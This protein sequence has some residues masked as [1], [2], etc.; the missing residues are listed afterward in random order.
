MNVKRGRRMLALALVGALLLACCGCFGG[1]VSSEVSSFTPSPTASP[2]PRP[3]TPIPS[4][5]PEPM[6]TYLSEAAPRDYIKFS[7]MV[8]RR[9]TIEEMQTLT[10][11]FLADFASATDARAQIERFLGYSRSMADMSDMYFYSFICFNQDVNDETQAEFDACEEVY[12]ESSNMIVEVYRA[13]LESPYEK[14]WDA[15]LG[16]GSLEE[17]RSAVDEYD[18]EVVE[19]FKQ[20]N[21]LIS[22]Y[23]RV[24][25]EFAQ[26]EIS[27]QGDKYPLG[28]MIWS[29]TYYSKK[30]PWFA[31]ELNAAIKKHVESFNKTADELFT[32]MLALRT[33]V[34]ERSGYENYAQYRLRNGSYT[35]QEVEQYIADVRETIVPVMRE[36]LTTAE[37]IMG[38]PVAAANYADAY[39]A[40]YFAAQFAFA[41]DTDTPEQAEQK[42]YDAAMQVLRALMPETSA[43]ADYLEE[44]EMIDAFSAANKNAGGFQGVFKAHQQPFIY[45]NSAKADTIL[46][47]A[48]HALN[49]YSLP[50][51][52]LSE[53]FEVGPEIAEI[54]SM[55]MEVL[56]QKEYDLLYGDNAGAARM[57][58]AFDALTN[59]L[60]QT[61]YYE[62]E[63]ELYKR[64]DMT[65]QERNDLF[66]SLRRDYARDV[67]GLVLLDDY[68]GQWV[69]I[70]HMFEQPFYVIDY[71][72]AQVVCLQ[73]NEAA[74]ENWET[75]RDLYMGFLLDNQELDLRT[76]LKTAGL[77]DPFEKETLGGIAGML[78]EAIRSEEYWEPLRAIYGDERE[79]TATDKAA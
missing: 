73:L 70:A 76:R 11:E 71:S 79:A 34:A 54:H 28:A 65:R 41:T 18:P 7:D 51:V 27:F 60:E 66:A 42:E 52:D 36:L 26:K 13:I 15:Y 61:M 59:V 19:L 21:K 1:Q 55:G 39:Y 67:E 24:A 4:P 17:M 2:T 37:G 20:V 69:Q 56:A 43:L 68:G 46:H 44:Y 23:T 16:E 64:P 32:Q 35:L 12:S 50:K 33:Q 62:F 29:V 75:A 8:Y 45:M 3:A 74:N 25:T 14:E 53:R 31:K 63:L 6:F 57:M 40:P 9:P 5:T 72:L 48:G 58:Q 38:E 10:D 78:T 30:E 22:E 47:E 77:A 49:T